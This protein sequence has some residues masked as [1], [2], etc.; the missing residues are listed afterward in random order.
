MSK[1]NPRDGY[2]GAANPA[3]CWFSQADNGFNAACAIVQLSPSLL[4]I[5]TA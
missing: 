5:S 2:M 4:I 3:D 1:K